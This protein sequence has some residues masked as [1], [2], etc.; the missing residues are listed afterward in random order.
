MLKFW[1]QSSVR[2]Y[3]ESYSN[4]RFSRTALFL[5]MTFAGEIDL[6]REGF[7]H[8]IKVHMITMIHRYVV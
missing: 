8:P 2:F 6:C 3:A 7:G 1:P 4:I 5:E